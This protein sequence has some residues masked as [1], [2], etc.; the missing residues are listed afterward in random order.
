LTIL[1]VGLVYSC[2]LNV[3]AVLPS[4]MCLEIVGGEG[5]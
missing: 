3:L 5:C 2:A 1:V 4:T